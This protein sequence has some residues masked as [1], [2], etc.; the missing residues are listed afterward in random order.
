MLFNHFTHEIK[1]SPVTLVWIAICRCGSYSISVKIENERHTQNNKLNKQL[2]L[3][4]GLK[5]WL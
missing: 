4:G 2:S 3:F 1:R 5:T